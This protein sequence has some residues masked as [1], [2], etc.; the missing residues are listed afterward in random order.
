MKT[1][2]IGI[3][4]GTASGKTTVAKKVY[5]ASKK[6]GSVTVIKLD[7]YYHCLDDLSMEDRKKVNYDHP[8]SFD[9]ELA[10]KHLQ[11]LKNG[12]AIDKPI[13]DFVIHNRK[14]ETERIEP[15][16]VVIMEGI[17]TFA[18]PE[19]KDMFDIKLFVDTPDDIRIIR[20]LTRD[21]KDRGRDLDSVIDQYVNTVRPMHLSFVETSKKYAD[22]IIPGGG[23]NEVA[24]DFIV[25]KIVD[26]LKK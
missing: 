1:T 17:L 21:I 25:T 8:S 15:K 3:A 24:I 23:N 26:L 6:Y 2:L 18:I 20:R 13:Y 11:D 14:K 7:D 16:N 4:G 19:I 10:V 22:I 12:K 9:V 5:E